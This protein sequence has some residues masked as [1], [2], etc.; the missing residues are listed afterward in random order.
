MLQL[1]LSNLNRNKVNVMPQEV[2]T[3]VQSNHT[4][5]KEDIFKQFPC[6]YDIYNEIL[7]ENKKNKSDPK[8]QE[9]NFNI[10]IENNSYIFNLYSQIDPFITLKNTRDQ[11]NSIIYFKKE[12]IKNLDNENQFFK[13]MGFSKKKNIKC[14]DIKNELKEDTNKFSDFTLQYICN[15]THTNLII[16]DYA[17]IIVECDSKYLNK[18]EI[19]S[20]NPKYTIIVIHPINKFDKISTETNI[21]EKLFHFL[22]IKD[23]NFEK[24]KNMQFNELKHILKFV[25]INN[26]NTIKKKEQ[27]IEFLK[28]KFIIYNK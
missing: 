6:P 25:S 18:K 28:N 12:L 1:I 17:D 19:V 24:I 21:E 11:Y 8:N 4:N 10:W 14:D 9:I 2:N 23:I 5:V 27:I 20:I 26:N 15:I 13:K 7:N 16:I 3:L 22:Q